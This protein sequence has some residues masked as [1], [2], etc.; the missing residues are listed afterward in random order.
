MATT[1]GQF[2]DL[3]N[4]AIEEIFFDV[5]DREPEEYKG[6]MGEE[7]TKYGEVKVS[8]V[9][10]LDAAKTFYEGEDIDIATPEQLYDYT[11]TVGDAGLGFEVTDNAMQDDRFDVI[12]KYP[13]KLALSMK[14]NYEI[15]AANLLNRAF[16]ASYVY[17]DAK[18]LCASDHP[19]TTG[20]THSNVL[21]SAAD[22]SYT[23]LKAASIQMRKFTD[24]NGKRARFIPVRIILPIDLEA[25]YYSIANA[26]A[27]P[28]S[29]QHDANI[30]GDKNEAGGKQEALYKMSPV[31]ITR[32]TDT[33]AWF[34]M[35]KGWD[36]YCLRM[37]WRQKADLLSDTTLSNRNLGYNSK[38]RYICGALPTA[39]WFILGTPGTP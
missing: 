29:A 13:G 11:F 20:R 34:I 3:Y 14:E 23:A 19:K 1:K 16:N 26:L 22:L 18:V 35:A 31:V 17:G 28:G 5:F 10:T 24:E 2:A 21:T 15:A 4:K 33:D 8:H 38:M 39:P 32:L 25:E 6:F 36:E 27:L 30:F 37:Y 7:T 12:R 9:S